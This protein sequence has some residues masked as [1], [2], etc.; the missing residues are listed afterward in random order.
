MLHCI[1]FAYSWYRS[2]SIFFVYVRLLHVRMQRASLL[3]HYMRERYLIGTQKETQRSNEQT[4]Q[5][6]HWQNQI[7]TMQ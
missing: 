6:C 7:K 2:F 5:L 3:I 4:V 1:P